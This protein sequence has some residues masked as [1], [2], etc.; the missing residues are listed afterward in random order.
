MNHNRR[1]VRNLSPIGG[2]ARMNVVHRVALTGYLASHAPSQN[3]SRRA[4]TANTKL[5]QNVKEFYKATCMDSAVALD[6]SYCELDAGD[7]VM[8]RS[9]VAEH[10]TLTSLTLRGNVLDSISCKLLLEMATA[11]RNLT[12]IDFEETNI[13]ETWRNR[14]E[15]Q[16]ER[17][18]LAVHNAINKRHAQ[19]QRKLLKTHTQQVETRSYEVMAQED[20]FRENISSQEISERNPL[21]QLFAREYREATLKTKRRRKL[22]ALRAKMD[23]VESDEE[24][25]RNEFWTMENTE[26]SV[27]CQL[28]YEI[29]RRIIAED[30]ERVRSVLKGE[31]KANWV[32]ARR[33]EKA[34]QKMEYDAR[35]AVGDQESSARKK[36]EDL[37]SEIVLAILR[38]GEQSY[39]TAYEKESIRKDKEAILEQQRKR[40]EDAAREKKEREEAHRLRMHQQ[41]LQDQFRNRE[42]MEQDHL[43]LRKPILSEEDFMFKLAMGAHKIVMDYLQVRD[44]VF[45]AEHALCKEM[46]VLPTF[47]IDNQ[48]STPRRYFHANTECILLC[49]QPRITFEIGHDAQWLQNV[50][51]IDTRLA[52]AVKAAKLEQ[53]KARL[54]YNKY[55]TEKCN[56]KLDPKTDS[57][58]KKFEAR[59]Q[60]IHH[61]SVTIE[62]PINPGRCTPEHRLAE[63]LT[64]WGG[65]ITVQIIRRDNF[66][67]AL[68][69]YD[70]LFVSTDWKVTP[71]TPQ[72]PTVKS[73]LQGPMEVFTIKR[74]HSSVCKEKIGDIS[75]VEGPKLYPPEEEVSVE[76]HYDNGGLHLPRVES[77]VLTLPDDGSVTPA[78][79][80]QVLSQIYYRN[81][82]P[83]LRDTGP[84]ERKI[85]V[86][87]S[88][89]VSNMSHP[90]TNPDTGVITKPS[91]TTTVTKSMSLAVVVS[92]QYIWI[93]PSSTSLEY[94]EGFTPEQ[95]RVAPRVQ[96]TD[97]PIVLLG[98]DDELFVEAG[99]GGRTTYVDGKVT[100]WFEAGCA[101]EDLIC[102]SST[103][104][105]MWLTDSQSIF[106]RNGNED[107]EIG[108][109]SGD[110][111]YRTNSIPALCSEFRRCELKITSKKCSAEWVRRFLSRLRY[112]NTAR[113]PIE[114]KR[115]VRISLSDAEGHVC[116]TGVDIEVI[117]HDDPAELVIDDRTTYHRQSHVLSEVRHFLDPA[118]QYTKICACG[119]I[120][121]DDTDRFLGGYIRVRLAE[122][123]HPGDTMILMCSP[124]PPLLT[125]PNVVE[126]CEEGTEAFDRKKSNVSNL[127]SNSSEHNGNEAA[128]TA[129]DKMSR[130]VSED[131]GGMAEAVEDKQDFTKLPTLYFQENKIF[132]EG[133]HIATITKGRPYE[134]L[135]LPDGIECSTEIHVEFT[136]DGACSISGAQEILRAFAFTSSLPQAT[137]GERRF[138]IELQLGNTV[139]KPRVNGTIKPYKYDPEQWPPLLQDYMCVV[140]TPPLFWVPD[141]YGNIEY[142]EGAGAVR[143]APFEFQLESIGKFDSFSR[144]YISIEVVGGLTNED[145]LGVRQLDDMKI[146]P[147]K[148][149]EPKKGT[150][151]PLSVPPTTGGKDAQADTPVGRSQRTTS[152]VR[153]N[154]MLKDRVREKAQ[155]TA[156]ENL[157]RRNQMLVEAMRELQRLM[158]DKHLL[159]ERFDAQAKVRDVFLHGTGPNAQPTATIFQSKNNIL[160]AFNGV[161]KRKD[162]VTAL[163]GLTYT[164][165][166]NNPEVLQKMIRVIFHDGAQSASQVIVNMNIL[167]VN[168]VTDIILRSEKTVLGECSTSAK[169]LG[170]YPL[171]NIGDVRLKDPDTVFFDGGSLTIE[172]SGGNT[173]QD[174]LDFM[175]PQQQALAWARAKRLGKGADETFTLPKIEYIVNRQGHELFLQ[176]DPN[177][178]ATITSTPTPEEKSLPANVSNNLVIQFNTRTPPVAHIELVQHCITCITYSQ[179]V[180]VIPKAGLRMYTI[181]VVDVNNPT[182]GNVRLALEYKTGLIRTPMKSPEETT[183]I[184]PRV[185]M[186]MGETPVPLFA[187]ISHGFLEKDKI[188]TSGYARVS[189]VNPGA[190]DVLAIGDKSFV[191]V[192]EGKEFGLYCG[193]D[194]FLAKYKAN[195]VGSIMFEFTWASKIKPKLLE[196]MLKSITLKIPEG[197]ELR[198]VRLEV[199]SA[200]NVDPTVCEVEVDVCTDVVL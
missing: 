189:I 163:K 19:Q 61:A 128:A 153:P 48:L 169:E 133:R 139:P 141:V 39:K 129:T 146:K 136:V 154:T 121:D 1:N 35:K 71:P 28:Q 134:C 113:D 120:V 145:L 77:F 171:V 78:K 84:F 11:N 148:E 194:I 193:K 54:E 152:T 3:A 12:F 199:A 2:N 127:T 187:S 167:S 55:K 197:D 119:K 22:E 40:A 192:K 67:D 38:D 195:V 4:A 162:V 124:Q 176:N 86:T 76:D 158:S 184:I 178:F 116:E 46:L 73:S 175:T 52:E 190:K 21:V 18:R 75:V 90:T 58:A 29:Q 138:E 49:P 196:D 7:Y 140:V 132:Y 30:Q 156:R 182:P 144:P 181:R 88:L 126:L 26:F 82:I 16:L 94:I 103:L 24:Y 110:M 130:R 47:D 50:T 149:E 70:R 15:D 183:F 23:D 180:G 5:N 57:Y 165:N 118:L 27:L 179:G 98:A 87:V 111:L 25:Y 101:T 174:I 159:L 109:L 31:V 173:G 33:A 107:V 100:I 108:K 6:V 198:T 53:K 51:D 170:C 66:D 95:C 172:L 92:P 185:S 164:N 191:I 137:L 143:L 91:H 69:Q 36:L 9:I 142:R 122:G 14:I 161:V 166:S 45:R 102:F 188:I 37:E 117:S 105:N 63:K 135:S 8:L 64:I 41:L 10:P 68:V 155:T 150:T 85:D 115:T 96:V 59:E 104:Q 160:V 123:I 147:R 177:P 20:A 106:V 74:K 200:A 34:R 151:P 80:E 17:N 44:A 72:P 89:I 60:M 157:A 186:V 93:P 99:G 97:P 83:T 13:S 56:E 32:I 125:L 79:I 43:T 65:K 168:D 112:H 81:A 114:G 131:A 62:T 42:R